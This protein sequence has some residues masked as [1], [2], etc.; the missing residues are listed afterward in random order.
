MG[1]K[2]NLLGKVKRE[3]AREQGRAGGVGWIPSQIGIQL[4]AAA[5][6]CD[7][8]GVACLHREELSSG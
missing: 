6:E 4:G 8:R 3:S 7:D 5:D 1:G 2:L